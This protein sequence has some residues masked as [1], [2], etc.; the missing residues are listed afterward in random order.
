VPFS[1][2][3]KLQ[4]H[5]PSADGWEGQPVGHEPEDLPGQFIIQGFRVKSMEC[6]C[7]AQAGNLYFSPVSLIS[8]GS[9][10]LKL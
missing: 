10:K 5:C 2:S 4:N 3:G 1:D 9:L 6:K 8:E 7:P